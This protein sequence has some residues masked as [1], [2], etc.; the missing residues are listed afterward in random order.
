MQPGDIIARSTGKTIDPSDQVSEPS[1]ASASPATRSTCASSAAAATRTFH[2]TLGTR[3]RAR[4]ELRRTARPARAGRCCRAA[5][6]AYVVRAAHRAQRRAP[7]SPPRALAG[8]GRAARARAGAGTLPMLAARARHRALIVAAAKPQRTVAV[9]VERASIMLADRRLRLDDRHR[10]SRPTASSAATPRRDAASSSS[11]PEAGERRRDGVQPDI[12]RVLQSPTQ[13]PRRRARRDSSS[14]TSSGG[15]ATGDAIRTAASVAAAGR[16]ASA[17]SRRRRRSCCSPTASRRSGRDPV[18]AA[19]AAGRRQIPIYT[20]ALGTATRHDHRAAQRGGGTVTEPRPARSRR[21][22]AQI[23]RASGGEAFT[24]ADA[25]RA[26]RR[27]TSGSA[28][29]SAAR[30]S[31]ARSLRCSPAARSRCCCA[32]LGTVPALVRPA[33]LNFQKGAHAMDMTTTPATPR[34]CARRRAAALDEA[35]YEIKRVI[36]GQDAMLERLLVALLAGGH[37]LLEGVPGL[38]K[39]LTVQHARAGARRHVPAASSSRRTSCPPTSSARASTARTRGAFDTEL[40]PVFGNFLLADEINRAPAKVQSALLE[41]MQEQPGDD[42]RRDVPRA[43]AVPRLATQNPIESEGTY[44]LPEAQVDRFL[45]KMLVDY[46]IDRRGGRRGRAAR[47]ASRPRCASCLALEDLERFAARHAQR[48]RR[49]RGDRLRGRAGRRDAPAGQ[50]GLG[51]LARLRRVRRQPARADRARPGRAR[52]RAAARPR[53]RRR[54]RDIRDL[55]P[56]V[57]R[58]RIVLSYDAL[59]RGRDRRRACSSACSSRGHRRRPPTTCPTR[60]G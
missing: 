44:P 2:V 36:V 5:G 4:R 35:L 38:A 58:H 20:V 55:A 53:P 26:V 7:R 9:P 10:T 59:S 17:A 51:D 21:R 13:R 22:C 52:A 29:S 42:R 46:P 12:A 11:V 23:A 30:R 54:P 27:S 24:A 18:A 1:T 16:P 33:H 31:S 19:Q 14:M 60:G 3:P 34:R 49:P 45:M 32:G 37:V 15:T 25:R 47:W 50:H 48:A 40:G 39:T 43:A 41:V 8:V 56:D 57:L 28:R 6:R